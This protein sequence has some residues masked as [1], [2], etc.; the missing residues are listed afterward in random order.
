MNDD[1]IKKYS[2]NLKHG[3]VFFK[4]NLKYSSCYLQ[5]LI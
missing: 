4:M 2:K 3:S 5:K 1:H